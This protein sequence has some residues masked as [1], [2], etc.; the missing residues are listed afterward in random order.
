MIHGELIEED[1]SMDYE[2][3][4]DPETGGIFLTATHT[5]VYTEQIELPSN[6][7]VLDEDY[8]YLDDLLIL[9]RMLEDNGIDAEIDAGGWS[10][11]GEVNIDHPKMT[12]VE[13][14]LTIIIANSPF[15]ISQTWERSTWVM[16][17]SEIAEWEE[18]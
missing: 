5:E 6:I 16:P 18:Y 7:T 3:N 17:D 15:T 12:H 1:A 9:S 11:A 2:Y 14:P 13:G 10:R 4:Y 8:E